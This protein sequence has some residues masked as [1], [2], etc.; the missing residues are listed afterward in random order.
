MGRSGPTSARMSRRS[1]PFAVEIALGDHRAVQVEVDPVE[2][3]G[4]R[5]SRMRPEM[6]SKASAVTGPLGSAE[7]HR[8]GIRVM[9]GC[10]R[11]GFG[12]PGD[13]QVHAVRAGD[14]L[15]PVRSGG[16]ASAI[17]NSASPRWWWRSC[18]SHAETRRWRCAARQYPAP[19]RRRCAGR[20]PHEPVEIVEEDGEGRVVPARVHGGAMRRDDRVLQAPRAGFRRAGARSRTRRARRRRGGRSSGPRPGR[21]GRRYRRARHRRGSRR[22]C[23]RQ[24]R[25]ADEPARGG[26]ERRADGDEIGAGQEGGKVGGG[27]DLVH[28]LHLAADGRGCRPRA[29]RAPWRARPATGRYARGRRSAAS[30]PPAGAPAGEV[31]V[32]RRLVGKKPGI[33]RVK[34]RKPPRM[35]SAIMSAATPAALVTV[36]LAGSHVP[37]WSMPTPPFATQRGPFL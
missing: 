31:P 1:A 5:P 8:I 37:K 36:T 13:G 19:D 4:G 35:Y 33:S 24:F 6:V 16:Q 27:R 21:P 34:C 29:C 30:D 26:G 14:D 28:V 12:E 7:H 20:A 18:W 10:A 11:G 25:R 3:R 22:V 32:A 2:R 9:S 15:R 23:Q 17:S